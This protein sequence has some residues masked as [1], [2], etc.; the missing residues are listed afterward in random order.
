VVEI[1]VQVNGKIKTR[2]NVAVGLEEAAARELLEKDGK[3]K[4]SLGAGK[5]QKFIWVKDKLANFI[6]RPS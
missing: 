1:V 4:T 5:V 6:V 2:V 3:I